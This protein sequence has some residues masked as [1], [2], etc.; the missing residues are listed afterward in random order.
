MVSHPFCRVHG[1]PA[2][3][4]IKSVTRESLNRK[5]VDTADS[6]VW[7]TH[8]RVWS[9]PYLGCPAHTLVWVALSHQ[10]W[11]TKR[12]NREADRGVKRIAEVVHRRTAND[13]GAL[14]SANDVL[15]LPTCAR[16]VI[17]HGCPSRQQSPAR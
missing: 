9:H 3:T 17:D 16:K 10:R 11:Q 4:G 2:L 1:A 14:G 6:V 13:I 8:T 15:G 12:R 5:E 7:A